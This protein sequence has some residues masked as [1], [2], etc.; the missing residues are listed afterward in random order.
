MNRTRLAQLLGCHVDTVNVYLREG[1]PVAVPGA[2]GK[3]SIYDAVECLE[4]WRSKRA[5]MSAAEAAK[6]RALEATARLNELKLAQQTS[7]LVPRDEVVREGQAYTKALASQVRSL[8]RRA[9]QAGVLSTPEQEAAL[10]QLC[11]QTL[12]A[13][14]SWSV[15]EDLQAASAATSTD[16]HLDAFDD[17]DSDQDSRGE[18]HQ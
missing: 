13:I 4:W 16:A 7:G 18:H 9:R 8:P 12:T 15:I 5:T 17:S 14:A 10:D 6:T 2:A 11:R 1:M 3:E